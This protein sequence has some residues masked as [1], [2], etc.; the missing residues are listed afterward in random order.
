MGDATRKLRGLIQDYPPF[1]N[2]PHP[3]A[4]VIVAGINISLLVT[5]LQFEFQVLFGA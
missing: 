4:D 5:F 1:P 3:L 2:G